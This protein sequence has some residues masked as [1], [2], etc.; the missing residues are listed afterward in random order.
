MPVPAVTVRPYKQVDLRGG[1]LLVSVPHAGIANLLLTDFL[2]EQQHMDQV[3]AL[4]SEAFPPFAMLHRGRPR[5]PVR[6]HADVGSRLAV[7]R[8]EFS[9]PGFLARPMAQTLL[10]WAGERGLRRVVVLDALHLV[11]PGTEGEGVPGAGDG[12]PPVWFAACSEATRRQALA[13]ELP[14]FEEGVLDGVPAMLLLEARFCDVDVVG[15]FVE[16]REALDDARGVV[17]LARELPKL[18][19]EVR[20]D[21]PTLEVRLS[22]VESAVR[23][24]RSQAE[25]VMEK[26]EGA[27]KAP[28]AMYG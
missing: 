14:Q 17:A 13:A 5:F 12:L 16:R 15:L 11:P 10:R 27:T 1:T 23:Q 8:C 18:A 9:P 24:A 4:D 26:L 3:A 20:L 21:L 25:K 7:L 28:P 19:P 2:L 22:E 6:L